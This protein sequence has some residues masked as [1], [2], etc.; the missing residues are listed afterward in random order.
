MKNGNKS[1][2]KHKS[3]SKQSSQ[4]K[5]IEDEME[6]CEIKETEEEAKAKEIMLN[7]M[8]KVVF[9]WAKCLL[10]AYLLTKH[11]F[12]PKIALETK[13]REVVGQAI[14]QKLGEGDH[15][16][17]FHILTESFY[18]NEQTTVHLVRLDKEESNLDKGRLSIPRDSTLMLC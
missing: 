14:R 12:P 2:R 10:Q 13:A 4:K 1:K 5:A 15:S 16:G 18:A 9:S 6:P 7:K 8:E 3:K 17:K 11:A